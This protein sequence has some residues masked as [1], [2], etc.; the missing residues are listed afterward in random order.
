MILG[1]SGI[2]AQ[3]LLLRE[4]LVAFS[5]NELYIGMFIGL[6]VAGEAFGAV[7]GERYNRSAK[8][9]ESIFVAVT[10][11]FIFIFPTALLLA[12]GWKSFFGVPLEVSSGLGLLSGVSAVVLLPVAIVHGFLFISACGIV[13]CAKSNCDNS[14]GLTYS[15]ETIGSIIGGALTS[16]TLIS[17][18]N[19]FDIAL[20]LAVFNAI[21]CT[22]LLIPNRNCRFFTGTAVFL[23]LLSFVLL[24]SGYGKQIHKNSITRQWGGKNLVSYRNSH[25]QNI[26]VVESAG[27]YTLFADGV[28]QITLPVPDIEYVEELAHLPLLMHPEPH[29]VLIIGGGAGGVITEILKHPSIRS[30]DYLE[31]DPLLLRSIKELPSSITGGELS[32]IKVSLIND[33]ARVFLR[34]TAK[35]YDVAVMNIPLPETLQ[36]NRFFT[37]QFFASIRSVLN[38]GGLLVVPSKGSLTYYSPEL[39]LLNASLL[40]TLKAVFTG[41]DV[42][43]GN[44]NLFIAGKVVCATPVASLLSRRQMEREIQARL[45]SPEHL[46]QRLADEE[47]NWVTGEFSRIATGVINE[48]FSPSLMYQNLSYASRVHSSILSKMLKV[49]S[50]LSLAQLAALFVSVLLIVAIFIKNARRTSLSLAVAC[51]GMSSMV[52]ELLLMAV[53]QVFYGSLFHLMGMLFALFMAGIGVGSYLATIETVRRISDVKIMTFLEFAMSFILLAQAGFLSFV[54][55]SAFE[56]TRLPFILAGLCFTGV[57]TGMT[58]PV[59]SRLYRDAGGNVATVGGAGSISGAGLIYAVDLLGGC[60]GG[61]IGGLIFFPALGMKGSFLVLGLIKVTT[62]LFFVKAWRS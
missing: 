37:R 62:A 25:Y 29:D 17:Q 16:F 11:G 7:W 28:P 2:V 56:A 54:G 6:W 12:R 30:I 46:S 9:P 27:Q 21:A 59:A 36:A 39:G 52:G 33:D 31:P 60:A 4:L 5:G 51:T 26:V 45:L 34:K 19:S 24:L 3:I 47:L 57:L 43:P 55:Q 41:V 44:T 42:I 35:R 53:F 8:E 38:D 50:R 22:L 1:F 18:L 15:M 61:I 20:L 13:R 58:Y 14:V 23:G 48:D 40:A 49:S 32:N 10:A